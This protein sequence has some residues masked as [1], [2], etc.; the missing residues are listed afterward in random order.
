MKIRLLML[1]LLYGLSINAFAQRCNTANDCSDGLFCT[2]AATCQNNMC[3]AGT[4]PNCDDGIACTIDSCNE[5]ANSCQ[6]LAPDRDNDGSG[7]ASCLDRLGEPLGRDCD[8]NNPK[9]FGGNLEVCDEND[10]DE[11]CDPSTF[12]TKDTDGDGFVDAECGNWEFYR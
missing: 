2:G 4:P 5:I 11:D 10:I 3:V 6:N 1:M 7:D 8:D 12:G 9:R